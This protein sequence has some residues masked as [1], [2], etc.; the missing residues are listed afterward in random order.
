M[1][2]RLLMLVLMLM[3]CQQEGGSSDISRTANSVR[4]NADE[5]NRSSQKSDANTFDVPLPE[6]PF[7]GITQR[8][9]IV[10]GRIE[11]A[12]VTVER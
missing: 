4:R 6:G 7:R 3:G 2:N 1:A 11:S 9:V 12:T 5:Q 10:N 8:V